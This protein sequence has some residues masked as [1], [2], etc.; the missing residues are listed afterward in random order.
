MTN[1]ILILPILGALLLDETVPCE[2]ECYSALSGQLL[3]WIQI[4][5]PIGVDN[6]RYSMIYVSVQ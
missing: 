2:A 1:L 3:K 5:R 6:V 4:L